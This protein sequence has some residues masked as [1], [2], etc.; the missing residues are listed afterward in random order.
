MS[1]TL[2]LSRPIAAT[3]IFTSEVLS[4]HWQ[5]LDEFEGDAYL[6]VQVL[7]KRRDGSI[8]QAY[9]FSLRNPSSD[10]TTK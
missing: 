8:I 1:V 6:R 7:A 2:A 4:A 3:R 10:T 5:R 9:V